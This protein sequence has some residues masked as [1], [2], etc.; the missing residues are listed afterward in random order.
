MSASACAAH[1]AD[2]PPA[3][4]PAPAPA[5]TVAVN[6]TVSGR[7]LADVAKDLAQRGLKIDQQLEPGGIIIGHASKDS[8]ATLRA[9][10]GVMAVEL[11]VP[12]QLPPADQPQ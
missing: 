8:L 1:N 3:P 7:P 2:P 6:V 11:D 9:V 4:A 5:E 10:A 12:V